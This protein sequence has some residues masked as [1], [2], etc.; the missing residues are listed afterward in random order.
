MVDTDFIFAVAAITDLLAN[1]WTG[2]DRVQ[3]GI[4]SG[5]CPTEERPCYSVTWGL[6]HSVQL[7]LHEDSTMSMYVADDCSELPAHSMY[8][9]LGYAEYHDIRI[10]DVETCSKCAAHIAACDERRRQR[11]EASS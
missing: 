3:G 8:A 6:A 9:M 4:C 11:A 10:E 1:T 2:K 5:S 7:T